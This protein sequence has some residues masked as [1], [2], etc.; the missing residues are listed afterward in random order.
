MRPAGTRCARRVSTTIKVCLLPN[1]ERADERCL[2]HGARPALR[3]VFEHVFGL[4]PETGD[5]IIAPDSFGQEGDPHD[6]EHV[7]G[8]VVGAVGD[9]AARRAQGGDGRN[10]PAVRCHGRLMRND[11]AGAAK[12]R[13]FGIVDVPAV[14]REQARTEEVVLFEESRRTGAMISQHEL[15]LGAALGQVDR[16]PQIVLLS[17][18]ADGVQE[19]GR[20][21]LRERGRRKHADTSLPCAV[22]GGEQVLNALQAFVSQ[23]G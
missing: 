20:R 11:G 6:L 3:C 19:L 8:V 21:V 16:V 15:D 9:G 23:P 22:P 7:V 10:D 18:R 12:Q 4:R 13:D 1:L 14:R 2:A 5:R 17:K